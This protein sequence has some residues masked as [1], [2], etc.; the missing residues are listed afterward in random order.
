MPSG[1][2]LGACLAVIAAFSLST[3]TGCTTTGSAPGTGRVSQNYDADRGEYV[4]VLEGMSLRLKNLDGSTKAPTSSGQP[5]VMDLKAVGSGGNANLFVSVLEVEAPL[6]DRCEPR[7]LVVDRDVL[8]A[9]PPDHR[10][11]P[12]KSGRF[13]EQLSFALGK[14][15]LD[16]IQNARLIGGR[17]CEDTFTLSDDQRK[18]LQD[19]AARARGVDG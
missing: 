11:T 19:W 10:L 8:R 13:V 16:A 12:L 4:M 5:R 1:V 14:D 18:A 2:G 7:A 15:G 6:L 3:T 9:P 17:L